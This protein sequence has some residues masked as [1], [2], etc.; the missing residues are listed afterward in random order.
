MLFHEVYGNYYH[1]VA[2]ILKEA[3]EE[4]ITGKEMDRL[5]QKHAFGESFLA[6]PEGL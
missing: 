6:I 5:I 1:A 2:S 3:V 4:N